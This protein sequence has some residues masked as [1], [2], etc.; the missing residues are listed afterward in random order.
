MTDKPQTTR[1]AGRPSKKEPLLPPVSWKA[2][3]VRIWK[4]GNYVHFYVSLINYSKHISAKIKKEGLTD[5]EVSLFISAA[6]TN[7]LT[8]MNQMR[9]KV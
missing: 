8:G 3:D 4:N 2:S 9:R 5:F 6:I 7:A 1:K